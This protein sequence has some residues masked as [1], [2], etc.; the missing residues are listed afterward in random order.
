MVQDIINDSSQTRAPTGCCI[1]G[2]I[3]AIIAALFYPIRFIVVGLWRLA[4]HILKGIYYFVAWPLL[5]F[6]Y[7]WRRGGGWR[8]I[9]IIFGVLFALVYGVISLAAPSTATIADATTPT[10]AA[11][12]STPTNQANVVQATAFPTA[13]ASASP[14][15][16]TYSPTSQASATPPPV[17]A[18]DT[19]TATDIPAPTATDI[20]APTATDIPA[21]TAVAQTTDAPSVRS[22]AQTVDAAWVQVNV[23]RVADGDT[24][25]VK[26]NG[27]NTSVRLIGVDTPETVDPRKPVQCY[28][29]EASNYT[30]SQLNK[31]TI[32]L[33]FDE[34]QGVTDR[35]DRLL[36]FVRRA[37]GSLFNYDLIANGY[38]FEYTYQGNPYRY[39]SEFL[40]A[41]REARENG[42]GLWAASTCNGITGSATTSAASTT[43]GQ[44]QSAT[45][46]TAAP[47]LTAADEA[48]PCQV[49]QIKGNRNSKIYHVPG[50]ASY[51]KT[52]ANVEC[53]DSE[54]A[55]ASAGYRK[56]KR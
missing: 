44:G 32:Y 56:A 21:P 29:V 12:T 18:T 52:K 26:Y 6:E 1:I 46:A 38:A 15:P 30:K 54:A 19:A 42:R 11:L 10:V 41:A 5:A 25:T 45:I 36:A 3:V 49:N 14:L 39:Q 16:A 4:P 28:G 17:V 50:G 8:V 37:D 2:F 47:A 31:Q 53:F 35:Y 24:I 23:V 40:A 34:S 7:A 51:A 43:G 22:S 13:V 48:A 55:A 20:P 27:V 33:E 9:A